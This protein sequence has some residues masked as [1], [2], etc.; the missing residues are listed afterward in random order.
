MVCAYIRFSHTH[1]LCEQKQAEI[2]VSQRS[3]IK[4]FCDAGQ[5]LRHGDRRDKQQQLQQQLLSLDQQL[6]D[7]DDGRRQQQEQQEQ[8]DQDDDRPRSGQ[9][10][11]DPWAFRLNVCSLLLSSAL[12]LILLKVLGKK[13]EESPG[14]LAPVDMD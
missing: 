8:P 12:T 2:A 14:P 5:R 4:G 3:Y 6:E 7:G 10:A 9:W 13:R 11:V 1:T